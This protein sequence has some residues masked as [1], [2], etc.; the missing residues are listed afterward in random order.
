MFTLLI[1]VLLQDTHYLLACEQL[2]AGNSLLVPDDHTDLRGTGALLSH[3]DDELSDAL[4]S[5]GDPLG[6]FSFEGGGGRTDTLALSLALDSSHDN[7][8]NIN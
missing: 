3:G 6:D 2:G 1:T 4:G 7:C 8:G 5:V